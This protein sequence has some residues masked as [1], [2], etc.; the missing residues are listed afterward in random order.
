MYAAIL[1]DVVC[2]YSN[3]WLTLDKRVDEYMG[4]KSF[5]LLHV[6]GTLHLSN[7]LCCDPA[8]VVFVYKTIKIRW[9]SGT[10]ESNVVMS[11]PVLYPSFIKC[12]F[13]YQW[14]L[15]DVRYSRALAGKKAGEI[16]KSQ[17]VIHRSLFII[18]RY[19]D[20]G[21]PEG[22]KGTWPSTWNLLSVPL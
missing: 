13:E 10:F 3:N 17:T 20:S 16:L 8:S 15:E 12:C 21:C 11:V 6:A 18:V 14:S 19:F 7:F 1:W 22:R 4:N 2:S 9:H 5:W